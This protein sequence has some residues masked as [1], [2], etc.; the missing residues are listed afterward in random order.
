MYNDLR[1]GDHILRDPLNAFGSFGFNGGSLKLAGGVNRELSREGQMWVA[2]IALVILTT[3]YIQDLKDQVGDKLRNRKN[4]PILLGDGLCRVVIAAFV[5]F[6]A[7]ACASF[8]HIK[9][10]AFCLPVLLGAGIELNGLLR[11]TVKADYATWRTW[12][13]WLIV[14][15]MLPAL[16]RF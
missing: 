9:P 8:F 16:T 13:V 10:W 7:F 3:G 5:I 11:R 14:L 6:W 15:F 2:M 4:V 12:C 1:G